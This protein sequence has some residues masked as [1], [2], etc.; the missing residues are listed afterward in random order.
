MGPRVGSAQDIPGAAWPPPLLKPLQEGLAQAL[1]APSP[2]PPA[3][4]SAA[5]CPMT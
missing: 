5:T 3:S 4:P 2:V 1:A